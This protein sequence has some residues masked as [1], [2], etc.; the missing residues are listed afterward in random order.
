M[1]F[2]CGGI[3]ALGRYQAS[4]ATSEE[5]RYRSRKKRIATYD[6]VESRRVCISDVI[7]KIAIRA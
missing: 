5:V 1:A 2:E 6:F 3:P 4:F 7:K